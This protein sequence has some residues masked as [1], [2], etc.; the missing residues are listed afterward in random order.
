LPIHCCHGKEISITLSECVSVRVVMQ[1]AKHMHH[2]ILSSVAWPA[3]PHFSTL[4]HQMA[5]FSVNNEHKMCV[6]ILCTILSE[7]FYILGS[8]QWDMIINV[9]RSSCK[10]PIILD[11]VYW[12]LNFLNT[13]SKK[14]SN[15]KFHENLSSESWVVPW[16][17]TDMTQLMVTKLFNAE[18]LIKTSRR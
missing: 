18:R 9:H 17:Q 1:H 12:N 11:R 5:W 3:L 4:F 10:A 15:T 14:N 2:T 7:K 16:G 13:F 8:T 6:L